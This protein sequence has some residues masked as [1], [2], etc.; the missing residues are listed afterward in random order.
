MT[1]TAPMARRPAQQGESTPP[2]LTLC[3]ASYNRVA[4]LPRL[5]ES[6]CQQVAPGTAVEW[7]AIDDG[8]SDGTPALLAEFSCIRP[9]LVRG[10]RVPR[11]GKHR[12]LNRAAKAARGEWLLIVDSD[13]R[14][15]PEVI[16]GILARL[17]SLPPA[18]HIGVLRG[19]KRFPDRPGP[20]RAFRV[21]ANPARHEDW[22]CAQRPFE[23]AEIVLRSALLR[24]P[25]PEH[26][27]EIF[28]A[29]G[30]LW[31]ALDRCYRTAY[32]DQV[33]IECFYQPDGLSA[34]SRQLRAGAPCSAMEVYAA[35]GRANVIWKVRARAAANWWRYHF[36]ARQRGRVGH[37]PAAVSVVYAPAGWLLFWVDQLLIRAVEPLRASHPEP[38]LSA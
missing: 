10:L 19:L 16:P 1:V 6:I 23:T 5:F 38:E 33:W 8:S 9:D 25:F 17:Q 31:H 3:T 15:A 28:M 2:I 11:G 35:M 20:P 7:L 29:E 27:G 12:A 37:E 24:H 22:I 34:R 32:H 4:L 14:L 30:W 21:P 36:H 26:E 18:D 13:D